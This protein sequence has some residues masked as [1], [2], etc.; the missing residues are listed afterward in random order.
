MKLS[1][2]NNTGIKQ[3]LFNKR[4]L[5]CVFTGFSSGLPL[6]ILIALLPAWLRSEGVDL[7]SIGLFAL[8]QLPFTWKF[9]WAP[10]F[11]RYIPPLGRRRGW[12]LIMQL[13][14]LLS[15][16]VFGVLHPGLDLWG[17]AYLAG[18]VAFFSASQ[19]VVLDA[20]RR[21]L[22]L[23]DELGLGNAVHVNAYKIA[24]L[25]PGSFSLI[26]ADYMSWAGVFIITAC[27]MLPGIVMTLLVSEPTIKMGAPKTLRA[28]VV[29]PFQEFIGR[30]G[31]RS[32]G[33]I[34]GFIFFY[35]L[36]DSMA[37][38]LATP[39]YLDMGF[40]KT[41][42]GLVAKNAGLWP[43]V[44]G[45]LLGGI[46]MVRLGINRALWIFGLVQ[47]LAILGFAWLV[48]AGHSLL[49]LGVV[50]GVEALG[51]GLGTA[52]FVAF[53]AHTT[54]PLYTATQFALFT[55]LAA[56]PRTFANAA[57]GYLVEWFGWEAFFLF[58]FVIAIPGMLFL[59][60][61]APWNGR[62]AQIVELGSYKA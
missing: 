26:L 35:K 33:F 43:S 17:I 49:W 42:I 31:L 52:A 45:G 23:D 56:V 55:S 2:A 11:D 36:G 40:S 20:Y 53:I 50:I 14:L 21:E 57:T 38:A 6:Y 46:W 32:A 62:Q 13:A 18:V 25:V 4:M 7:K 5:I 3:A 41:E 29:E 47:M 60:K 58:C 34:L 39:F 12:I 59:L 54:H 16:P 9:L 51:V 61:V 24:G 28:A 10:L 48:S 15:I 44:A 27:F 19:D 1:V 22:L 37:T 8:I 30:N